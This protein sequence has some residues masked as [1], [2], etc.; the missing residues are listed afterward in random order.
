MPRSRK[1]TTSG[2]VA[3]IELVREKVSSFDE[4]P[5]SIPA[6]RQLNR[7]ELHPKVTF[8]VGE[9]GSGK[10]TLVEAIAV[11]L[12]I[13]PEVVTISRIDEYGTPWFDYVF[14]A[15]DLHSIGIME[16]ASWE[17]VDGC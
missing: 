12:G 1:Q 3:H 8:F 15:R 11:A 7:L 13:N 14:S 16:D 10:S 2:R 9:N 5:F 6:V 17:H 4:Y